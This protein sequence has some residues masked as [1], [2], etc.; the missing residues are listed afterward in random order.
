METGYTKLALFAS[1][2]LVAIT[3]MSSYAINSNGSTGNM[4]VIFPMHDEI[5]Q[6]YK[7][8]G[9]FQYPSIINN[10]T[11]G[12]VVDIQTATAGNS[13][14]IVWQSND[15]QSDH[16]YVNLALNGG[17]SFQQN[18][19]ELTPDTTGNISDLHVRADT[20]SV[21]VVWLDKNKDQGQV[22]VSSSMDGGQLFRTYV[23]NTEA[24][25]KIVTISDD[26][27]IIWQTGNNC[28]NTTQPQPD[29]SCRVYSQSRRW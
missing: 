21:E 4:K 29:P 24:N 28:D 5:V 2:L 10:N 27:I 14:W 8:L 16:V 20:E 19:T 22:Y 25:A 11:G 18:A 7:S 17:M 6:Y 1:V 12:N 13:T 26:G 9:N 3:P 23:M 15:G